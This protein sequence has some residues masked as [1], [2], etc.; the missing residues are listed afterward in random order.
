MPKSYNINGYKALLIAGVAAA[1][2]ALLPISANAQVVKPADQAKAARQH[3]QI[4]AQ[5]GGAIEGPLAEY[6]SR[7]GEKTAVAANLAGKCRFTVINSDVVN[8]FAVPGCYIYVTRGLLTIMNSEDELAAVLGHEIG[9][10]EGKHAYRRQRAST[11]STLGAIALGAATKSQDV[12]QQAGQLAQA[13]TLSYSRDQEHQ[14][15]DFGVRHLQANGYNMFAAS[16]IMAA[17]GAQEALDARVNNREARQIPNWARSHPVSAER[18][19]RTTTAATR[20][21]GTRSSP[22][23]IVRPFFNAINGLRVGDDPEQGFVNG[24]VFAHPTIKITFEVPVGY[25]LSNSPQAVQIQGPNSIRAQFTGGENLNGGLDTYANSAL[26]AILGQTPAQ[27][28]TPQ[29]ANV[30]GVPAV[31]LLARAQTRS[32]QAMDVAIMAY[33]VNNKGYHFAIVGPAGQLN[34]TF[35]MTQSMRILSDQEIAQM[36]PRQLEIVTVRNGDTIA[37]LSSRMAYPD[38]QAD[39]FKMLNAIATDRALVP[40]EQL[41]I[42]TYGAPAR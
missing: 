29:A 38:F 33:N 25:A 14:S 13:Y 2:M 28:G 27:V 16:D 41:K 36:R 32:G 42:V 21:G 40:G 5:F 12:M 11:L 37:S 20:A 22:P 30:N 31:S 6:V 8:A 23:E 35:P 39:R 17:L 19:S 1:A 4:V 3:P 9:H 15:D 18:V 24:R 10:I 34:P 7:I 26:R